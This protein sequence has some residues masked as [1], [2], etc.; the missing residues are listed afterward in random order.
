MPQEH[1][2]PGNAAASDAAAQAPATRLVTVTLSAYKRAEYVETLEVPADLSDDEAQRLAEQRYRFV[3]GGQFVEDPEYWDRGES[4]VQPAS[5]A[6]RMSLTGVVTRGEDGDLL[7]R[8]IP[9]KLAAA[10]HWE[11][12][13][14]DG[15]IVTRWVYD[16][17]EQKLK[18]AQVRR[19]DGVNQRWDWMLAR[20]AID[21]AGS[22]RDNLSLNQ[23]DA[24]GIEMLQHP[25]QWAIPAFNM[26]ARDDADW[27]MAQ[28]LRAAMINQPS[29]AASESNDEQPPRERP[30]G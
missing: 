14:G 5:E 3:D 1:D 12:L 27:A 8:E 7:V 21:L 2:S 28:Q 10:E 24:L 23:A 17:E 11:Q 29:G 16:V 25:P 19:F 26:D 13:G 30:R 18:A 22:I 15:M 4:S 9:A 20:D 6:D